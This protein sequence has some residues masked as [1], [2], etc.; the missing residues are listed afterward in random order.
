MATTAVGGRYRLGEVVGR[1]GMAEVYRA[2]DTR[3]ERPVAVKVL[4]DTVEGADR[5]RFATEARTLARLSHGGLVTLLDAGTVEH[6]PFLVMELVEGPTLATVLR[7]GP[8]PVEEAAKIGSQLADA[9]S[10]AHSMGVVHRDVKPANVLLTDSG[11]VKLADFGI[12]R[13]VGDTVRHTSP[14]TTIGTAAYLSPEQ[15]QGHPVGPPSDVY[16]LGLVILEALTA[17]PVYPGPATEAAL[18][19]LHQPPEIPE[20]LPGHLGELLAAMTALEPSHRP[21]AGLVAER[22]GAPSAVRHPMGGARGEPADRE[23]GSTKVLTAQSQVPPPGGRARGW[24][25]RRRG[26]AAAVAV[27]ATLVLALAVLDG[28]TGGDEQIPD[29]TPTELREPLQDLHD[30]VHGTG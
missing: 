5:D 4:R 3:L 2:L 8:L 30:A 13:L 7:E 24:S 27:V 23:A 14:G 17:R 26:A 9:L 11:R 28:T 29:G 19:R 15:V 6:Q 16:S 20:H 25:N 22:I 10:Y 12:A 21:S 1:G 18:A